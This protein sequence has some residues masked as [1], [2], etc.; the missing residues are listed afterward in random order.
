[1]WEL[2]R[3]ERWSLCSIIYYELFNEFE[4]KAV[5]HLPSVTY[6]AVNKRKVI[7]Q[8]QV[9][10]GNTDDANEQLSVSDKFR[11]TSFIPIIDVL[12]INLSLRAS[13]YHKL[14]RQFDCLI[15]LNLSDNERDNH[16]KVSID[17]YSDDNDDNLLPELAQFHA[18]IK[19]S[20]TH[21]DTVLLV[22]HQDLYTMISHDGIQSAFPN[23]E[24][25]LRIFLSVMVTNCSG[26]R[27]FS[28]LKQI[29]S[30]IRS[31]MTQTRL[32]SLSLLCMECDKM[33]ELKFDDVINDFALQ[34]SR[35]KI[36]L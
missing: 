28:Q 34:K 31:T 4:A 1:M 29:K 18:Y 17:A 10:D 30:E 13:V 35:K 22:T 25:I 11:V 8:K 5:N 12:V 7:R 16:A 2:V 3:G 27:S 24:V 26:E 9:N 15:D 23:V 19:A 36:F 6:R 20:K 21:N 33:R 32:S 14:A